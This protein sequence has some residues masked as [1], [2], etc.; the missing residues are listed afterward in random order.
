MIAAAQSW[1]NYLL[2]SFLFLL[3]KKNR[4]GPYLRVQWYYYALLAL[5]DVE[6]NFLIVK[7]YDDGATI[8]SAMLLDSFVIP[9]V[10]LLS[11]LF[12]N[13][14]Y[15]ATHCAGVVLC[16][17]GLVVLVFA[18]YY[19]DKTKDF[20]GAN[21]TTT[22]S[23]PSQPTSTLTGDLLVTVST[24]FYACS[25]VGQETMVKKFDKWEFLGSTCAE[26]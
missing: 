21:S 9:Q 10:M 23:D 15:Y 1:G 16:L 24:V 14:R 8:T 12:L 2:L 26:I 5:L 19:N 18:D 4:N 20:P 11:Y 22:S 6:G 7:G 25:N 13:H 17:V 3:R